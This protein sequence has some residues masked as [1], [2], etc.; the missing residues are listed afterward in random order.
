MMRTMVG[1]W[2]VYRYETVG[3][4]Q[5]VAADLLAAGAAH[6]TAIVANRQTAGYG[7]K[8]GTW[9]DEPGA[10][11]LMTLI[12]KPPEASQMPHLAMIAA[13]AV[14]DTIAAVGQVH[15]VIKWPNDILLNDRKVAGIL[16]DATWRGSHLEAVRLGIGLNVGG[17]RASFT[18]RSLPDATSIAAETGRNID[19]KAVL[20]ALLTHFAARE[21][22]LD[23]GEAAET[24][25]AWRR[26]VITI[27]RAVIVTLRDDRVIRGFAEDVT[28]DGDLIVRTDEGT[29]LHLAASETRSLRHVSPM[30]NNLP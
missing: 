16:G 24:V 22:R 10:S 5:Q 25:G 12:L 21:D 11:L 19:R 9:H 15:A 26:A 17:D 28:R 18:C 2:I 8:G 27:G 23:C 3:S 30:V 6:R 14:I 29:S 20:A 13:L 7:R 1:P 4:T